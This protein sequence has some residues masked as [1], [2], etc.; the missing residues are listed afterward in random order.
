MGLC[1]TIHMRRGKWPRPSLD[2]VRRLSCG[3]SKSGA[4]C[5]RLDQCCSVCL[6]FEH[7][8]CRSAAWRD[9]KQQPGLGRLSPATLRSGRRHTMCGINSS[10]TTIAY[11]LANNS[12]MAP[13]CLALVSSK[14]LDL[15]ACICRSRQHCRC[16][17]R[18]CGH[19][20]YAG[21]TAAAEGTSSPL[22]IPSARSVG[23]CRSETLP[24]EQQ[25][26]FQKRQ[27]CC[28]PSQQIAVSFHQILHQHVGHHIP[29]SL[30]KL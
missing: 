20:N 15:Y 18:L 12:R 6:L 25:T 28:C 19:S 30:P 11:G 8:H 22:C 10:V 5:S 21:H 3:T 7:G 13:L 2:R 29:V 26:E 16:S 27:G 9:G 17:T 23:I 24:L 4:Q 1:N 14:T